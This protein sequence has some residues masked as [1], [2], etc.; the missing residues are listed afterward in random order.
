MS[1]IMTASSTSST[2]EGIHTR[3]A[4]RASIPATAAATSSRTGRTRSGSLGVYASHPAKRILISTHAS[5]VSCFASPASTPSLSSPLLARCA[6]QGQTSNPSR[7]RRS[8][9]R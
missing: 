4:M 6:Q 3:Q 5:D 1:S 8:E 7:C 9:M 2:E